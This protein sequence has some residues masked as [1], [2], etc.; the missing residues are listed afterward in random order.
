MVKSTSLT[1]YASVTSEIE[2]SMHV[3]IDPNIGFLANYST[4]FLKVNSFVQPNFQTDNFAQRI[5]PEV[6]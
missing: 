4:D 1:R 2:S 6:P 3:F 5:W